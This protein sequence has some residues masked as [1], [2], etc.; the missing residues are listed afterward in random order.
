MAI[1]ENTSRE[2]KF[3]EK[4]FN[5]LRKISNK[6]TG[7]IVGDDKYD[8]YY[9]RL[10]KRIRHLGLKSFAEYVKYLNN[11]YDSEFTPFIDSI[12]TNLTSFFREIHH[13]EKLKNE[14]VPE[15]VTRIGSNGSLK[16]WS[17]G[18]STGEEPYTIA[19][20]LLEA[21]AGNHQIKP[22]IFAS[23][24][25]TTVLATASAGIYDISRIESLP[26]S[27]KKKWFLKGK[28]KMAGR[29]RVSPALRNIISFNQVNLMEQWPQV[30]TKFHII[31][32]RNV[33][34]YFDRPTKQTLLNRYADQLED[35]G[36][37]ILGH[38]ESLQGLSDRFETIGK[39]IYRKIK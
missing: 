23:D 4:D 30:R 2:F 17:A 34:I 8:M 10:V 29:V 35:N 39:T 24:I 15:L 22:S 32:C 26:M 3:T 11:N 33:V 12:T 7:I 6:H 1:I 20:T 5:A 19:I 28:G 37:L 27:M 25:D 38:S 18:C 14:I 9:S 31:F 16:V 36:Y 21:L 13:F